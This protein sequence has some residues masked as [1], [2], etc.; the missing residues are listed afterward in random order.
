M[1]HPYFAY[2]I[3]KRGHSPSRS[4]LYAGIQRVPTSRQ[5]PRGSSLLRPLSALFNKSADVLAG[6]IWSQR[7]SEGL[8]ES[9]GSTPI[10][11]SRESSLY[12]ERSRGGDIGRGG[13]S[14]WTKLAGYVS[15]QSASRLLPKS[16]KASSVK[17]AADERITMIPRI[18]TRRNRAATMKSLSVKLK[19]RTLSPKIASNLNTSISPGKITPISQHNGHFFVAFTASHC[20]LFWVC[21]PGNAIALGGMGMLVVYAIMMMA[22]TA[23]T[24]VTFG[25]SSSAL[26]Q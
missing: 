18:H 7:T 19:S 12:F 15:P 8:S 24:W 13:R 20:L 6:S 14:H 2:G 10:N 22:L 4:D 17:G 23:L 21:P 1:L 9:T 16:L 5:L 3:R 11:H 25:N 26:K